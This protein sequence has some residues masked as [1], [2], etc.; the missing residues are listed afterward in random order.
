MKTLLTICPY[1]VITLH[2]SA[3]EPGTDS[4][5]LLWATRDEVS[6]DW[7]LPEKGKTSSWAGRNGRE[8]GRGREYMI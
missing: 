4:T 6:E 5:Y 8:P 1:S 3:S 7:R 2:G